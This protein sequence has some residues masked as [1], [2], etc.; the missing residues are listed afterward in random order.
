MGI[1]LN[2]PHRLKT[3]RW[4]KKRKI[5]I[6]N[7][8]IWNVAF[9]EGAEI[10]P[11]TAWKVF[12]KTAASMYRDGC[13][14]VE[15]IDARSPEK[16]SYGIWWSSKRYDFIPIA[17]TFDSE[18][19][20]DGAWYL[21]EPLHDDETYP[22]IQRPQRFLSEV[23]NKDEIERSR[24]QY[25]SDYTKW[26][27]SKCAQELLLEYSPHYKVSLFVAEDSY[28]TAP[29]LIL[30]KRW[31][32]IPDNVSAANRRNLTRDA[33]VRNLESELY[34]RLGLEPTQTYKRNGVS[35]LME[36]D[37]FVVSFIPA[38]LS[39]RSKFLDIDWPKWWLRIYEGDST[40]YQLACLLW[41]DWILK[42]LRELVSLDKSLNDP[43]LL[44]FN[45][46]KSCLIPRETLVESTVDSVHVIQFHLLQALPVRPIGY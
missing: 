4:Y 18:T 3:P 32:S 45:Y 17:H 5:Q 44:R 33:F 11:N 22:V 43:D 20:P 35:L 15:N 8:D 19:L 26:A 6:E 10:D 41:C 23:E 21:D 27:I 13:F 16:V 1:L 42:S 46:S 29:S 40:A 37:A 30:S 31:S 25:I 9:P 28:L 38:T 34:K 2:M 24:R 12:W 36:D 7:M 14:R 39:L